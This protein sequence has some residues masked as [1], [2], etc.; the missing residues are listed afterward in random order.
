MNK[1]LYV[2][3]SNRSFGNS[4][5][6]LISVDISRYPIPP[7][8]AKVTSA[9][10]PYSW[11]NVDSTN[12]NFYLTEIPSPSQLVTI[13]PGNYTGTTL[14]LAL[15]SALNLA[16]PN[17]KT[18]TVSY[19]STTLKFTIT[20][21]VPTFSLS[22][23]VANNMHA[24]LGFPNNYV[25]PDVASVTSNELSVINPIKEVMIRSNIVG[26]IDNGY[27]ILTDVPSDDEIL[28]V[29]PTTGIF[30]SDIRYVSNPDEPF[31]CVS[32]SVLGMLPRNSSLDLRFYVTSPDGTLIDLNDMNWSLVLTLSFS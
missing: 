25:T 6:F 23:N 24:I 17:L 15:Q 19:D 3:S 2:S 9:T 27:G 16:S 26:G 22:F 4:N 31:C 18:Y 21:N 28:C 8:Y 14:A 12:N 5:D 7:K 1:L 32:Q 29:V 10:V 13:L 30:G 20:V 11:Y